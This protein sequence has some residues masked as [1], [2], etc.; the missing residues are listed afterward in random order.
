[1]TKDNKE[2]TKKQIYDSS[3]YQKKK[4]EAEAKKQREKELAKARKQRYNFRQKVKKLEQAIMD[5]GNVDV[6]SFFLLVCSILEGI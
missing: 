4:A 1:M 6:S 5:G 2:K 3:R